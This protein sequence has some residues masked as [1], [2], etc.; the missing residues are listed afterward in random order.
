MPSNHELCY[1]FLLQGPLFFEV[2][3]SFTEI[4]PKII[5]RVLECNS[6]LQAR[7]VVFHP[8]IPPF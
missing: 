3:K 1:L 5:W 2:I 6:D 8:F 4:N 7:D